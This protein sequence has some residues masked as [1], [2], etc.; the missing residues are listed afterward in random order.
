MCVHPNRP[1]P[2][3]KY[4]NCHRVIPN[5]G[6]TRLLAYVVA[7]GPIRTAY[8][9]A[10]QVSF[11]KMFVNTKTQRDLTVPPRSILITYHLPRKKC[12]LPLLLPQPQTSPTRMSRQRPSW[13]TSILKTQHEWTRC[14]ITGTRAAKLV[15]TDLILRMMGLMMN[16]N[17]NQRRNPTKPCS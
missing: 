13:G 3:K 17:R 4:P 9:V 2:N 16:R 15:D 10:A 7:T 5:L 12:L 8:T 14:V 11:Q 6:R 1:Q